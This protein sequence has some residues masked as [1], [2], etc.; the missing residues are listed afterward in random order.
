MFFTIPLTI[1]IPLSAT[2]FNPCEN[3]LE[4]VP[5][6]PPVE[7]PARAPT[8]LNFAGLV[9]ARWFVN[10]FMPLPEKPPMGPEVAGPG[11]WDTAEKTSEAS[12]PKTG[13]TA[14]PVTYVFPMVIS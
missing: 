14:T 9:T 2:H 7:A 5:P 1:P 10:P 4:N 6:A 11:M 3:R 8:W 12:A 13:Y